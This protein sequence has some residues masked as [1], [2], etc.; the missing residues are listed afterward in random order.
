MVD[1]SNDELILRL[2]RLNRALEERI[3]IIESILV[4]EQ[5]KLNDTRDRAN[6]MFE[7]LKGRQ[8]FEDW[9]QVQ[10]MIRELDNDNKGSNEEGEGE[11]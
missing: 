3:E 10:T 1:T 2:F 6:L 5:T 4:Y 7:F 11:D 8:E 9:H